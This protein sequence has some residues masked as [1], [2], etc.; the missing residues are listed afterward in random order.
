MGKS[1][2]PRC[3]QTEY[4]DLA[5]FPPYIRDSIAGYIEN[6]VGKSAYE[7]LVLLRVL[8]STNYKPPVD[9]IFRS[10]DGLQAIDLNADCE[11]YCDTTVGYPI[12]SVL[13]GFRQNGL[14]ADL[15]F[16]MHLDSLGNV[17]DS[18]GFPKIG[19]NGF[20]LVPLD[21]FVS[22]LIEQRIPSNNL[23]IYLSCDESGSFSWL[24]AKKVSDGSI[25]G[26]SC[27]PQYEKLLMIDAVTGEEVDRPW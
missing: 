23:E 12:Y 24:A 20:H 9:T 1:F 4:S 15:Y 8:R 26:P 7:Y 5:G 13:Y 21:S 27:F 11:P 16:D 22:L 10:S 17:V 14:G 18:L 25:L 6:T 19:D 3:Y 2:Y